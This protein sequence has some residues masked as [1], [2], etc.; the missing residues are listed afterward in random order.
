MEL[1]GYLGWSVSDDDSC[2]LRIT[3]AKIGHLEG[4]YTYCRTG[5]H[6]P[7]GAFAIMAPGNEPGMLKDPVSIKDFAPTILTLFG[8]PC[9][10][11]DGKP[12]GAFTRA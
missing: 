5:D 9:D 10:D 2:K 3:S 11:L 8:L 12:I 7:Q 6:R 4:E 1:P